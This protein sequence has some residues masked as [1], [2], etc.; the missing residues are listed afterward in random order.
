LDGTGAPARGQELTVDAAS[1]TIC[2]SSSLTGTI[3]PD[4]DAVVQFSN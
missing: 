1:G 4:P 2:G 3:L